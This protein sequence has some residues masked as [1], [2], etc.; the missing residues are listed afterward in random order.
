MS[1]RVKGSETEQMLV[2]I[3]L[4]KSCY[5]SDLL[6]RVF[7]LVTCKHYR[8]KGGRDMVCIIS[9]PLDVRSARFLWGIKQ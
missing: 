3:E 6:V 2:D 5:I 8:P 9:L 1:S 4:L 7:S